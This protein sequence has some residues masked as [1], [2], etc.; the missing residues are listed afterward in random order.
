MTEKTWLFFVLT[1][2]AATAANAFTETSEMTLN[3]EKASALFADSD[4][5]IAEKYWLA[6]ESDTAESLVRRTLRRSTVGSDEWL[7]AFAALD[8]V[9]APDESLRPPEPEGDQE[10][11]AE[12][13]KFDILFDDAQ[14]LVEQ[15]QFEA[16]RGVIATLVAESDNVDDLTRLS[17]LMPQLVEEKTSA[18][19][20]WEQTSEARS[21]FTSILIVM[22]SISAIWALLVILRGVYRKS[23]KKERWSVDRVQDDSGR[24]VSDWITFELGRE[25]PPVPTT[26]GLLKLESTVVPPIPVQAQREKVDLEPAIDALPDI[27]GVDPNAVAKGFASLK[28]WFTSCPPWIRGSA[29]IDNGRIVARLKA[30]KRNGQVVFAIASKNEAD[31]NAAMK[32]AAEVTFKMLYMLESGK[33]DIREADAA[34]AVRSG[35]ELVNEYLSGAHGSQLQDAVGYFQKSRIIGNV[36]R[37]SYLYE[38]IALDLMEEHDQ[39][40]RRFCYVQRKAD[41]GNQPELADK[42]KYNEAIARF[43]KYEPWQLLQAETL[44]F[45]LVEDQDLTTSPI[46]ALAHAAKANVIAHKPIFWDKLPQPYQ[47]DAK[48]DD[49][50]V[51]RK[52]E[53][54]DT[55][56][57]W[58]KEVYEITESLV[59]LDTSKR[60]EIGTGGDQAD[61]P[62]T[63]SIWDELSKRQLTWAIHNARGNANLN[64]AN[65]FLSEPV[66][67]ELPSDEER[68]G[69][70]KEAE[71]QF[72]E[73]ELLLPPGVETLTN[74]AT[75]LFK[76]GNT[77]EAIEYAE[78][79]IELNPEYEYAYYRLAMFWKSKGERD[80][81]VKVLESYKKA[82]RIPSFEELFR[83]YYVRPVE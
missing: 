32:T 9:L 19:W 24:G 8:C 42:A 76:L 68:L 17:T 40:I 16:A 22:L 31:D 70:L 20:W 45:E 59:Q 62:K 27:G 6:G 11:T 12:E 29:T 78:H 2:L 55:V 10:P 73:C 37:E 60:R 64:Y 36:G 14:K 26:A 81:V 46:A 30:T 75:V 43:R 1:I 49:E 67:G 52:N 18:Q 66:G 53:R 34:S 54:F 48:D 38:G 65:R 25:R 74:L 82:P 41:E 79:A 35:L 47:D 39:A 3:C 7:A 77:R 80:E 13:L 4:L 58:Y 50:T 83:E 69:F 72:R 33:N 28:Q 44:L 23:V 71:K 51:A 21:I 61:K 5:A 56:Q 57:G 63:R 15:R